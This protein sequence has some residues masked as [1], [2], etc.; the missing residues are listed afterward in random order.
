MKI[1]LNKNHTSKFLNKDNLD[2]FYTKSSVVDNL[3]KEITLEDYDVVV[4]PAAGTGSWSS[5][6][7][8][9]I[10]I[11]IEPKHSDIMKGNFLEDDFLFD[12]M[13]KEKRILVIGNPPFGRGGSKAIKFI[14]KAAEFADTIAFILP[15]SFR[16]E[17]RQRRVDKNFWLIKDV[18][19]FEES[20]F[21]FEDED[22]FAPCVFQIWQ[23]SNEERDTTIKKVEPVGFSYPNVMN[24]KI[25]YGK[26]YDKKKQ[27]IIGVLREYI[28]EANANLVVRRVGGAAGTAYM[29]KIE[30]RSIPPNYFLWVDNPK[31]I[32]E[33][34]NKH[35][36][37]IH[38]TV[39]PQSLTKGELTTFINDLILKKYKGNQ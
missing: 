39:G 29:D 1:K 28:E 16:K 11:D 3:L 31:E 5:K 14:N 30:E 21:I 37:N 35:K 23:R 2:R 13:K 4:E 10:A 38:D 20:C 32:A 19:L 36:F 12:E 27:M 9:C 34:I 8:E 25:K 15:R 6:I 24:Y 17:S 18:D 26:F 7:E 22:Y 33:S